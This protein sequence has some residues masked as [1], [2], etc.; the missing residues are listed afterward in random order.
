MGCEYL[1]LISSGQFVLMLGIQQT[2]ICLLI[3]NYC[4]ADTSFRFFTRYCNCIRSTFFN[5][6]IKFIRKGD[7]YTFIDR[8]FIIFLNLK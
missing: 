4:K 8:Y 6:N 3:S 7:I 2:G 5:I 1:V